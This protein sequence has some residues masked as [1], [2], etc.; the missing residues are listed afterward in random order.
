MKIKLLIAFI[1]ISIF[2]FILSACSQPTSTGTGNAS[3]ESGNTAQKVSANAEIKRTELTENAQFAAEL[4]AEPRLVEAGKDTALTFTVKNKQGQ[5]ARDLKIVHEKP[6]HLL[7]VS[8]DLFQ[9]DHVHPEPQPDGSFRLN[10]KFS[11]GGVY[12]LYADFTPQ[13]SPQIVNV[14]DVTVGGEA[15][16]KTPLIADT[17][18][19]RTVDGLTFRLKVPQPIKAGA[20]VMLDF[21]VADAAGTAVTDLQPYLGA[22]AHFVVIS[23]DTTKFLH[24]HAMEGEIAEAKGTDGGAHDMQGHGNMQMD[25]NPDTTTPAKPTVRAHT[26]FPS[27]GLYK[28]WGQ[29]QRGGKVI[30][31]PF[32]L[33]IAPGEAATTSAAEVPPGAIKIDLSSKGFEPSQ[34]NVS[35][36]QTVKLAFSRKD[37]GNCGSEVVFTKLNL[38]KTLPAGKMTIVEITPTETG[39][40][41]FACGMDMLKGKLVVE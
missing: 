34:V 28:L 35:K 19:T 8:D 6:M 29:F 17:N 11:N 4:T 26:E 13:N 3:V 10:H 9:F 22:M 30:T 25:V 18:F 36:G 2:T 16:Q 24:V 32:V 5:V 21:F 1:S 33:N 41:A 31:V 7:V 20:G 15:R 37:D 27:P 14:F 23:E 40:L 38:K 39:D 12:K